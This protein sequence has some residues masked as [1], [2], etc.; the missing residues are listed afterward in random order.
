MYRTGGSR[1]RDHA[2]LRW[3][4]RTSAVLRPLDKA[5]PFFIN[6]A[7]S[8]DETRVAMFV[9]GDIWLY[10]LGTDARIRFTFDP[11]NDFA[12]VWSPDGLQVVFASNRRGPYDLYL[13]NANGT[14]GESPLFQNDARK[15]P[16]DWSRDGRFLLFD[17]WSEKTTFDIGA[18]AMPEGK[19][20]TVL[21]TEFEERSGRSR[22]TGGGSRISPTNPAASRSGSVRSRCPVRR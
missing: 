22:R 5:P 15:L 9:N 20:F 2:F 18:L 1:V 10:D 12:A 7:L 11:G 3:F 17:T 8:P 4:D 19:P 21:A 14:G 13:K 16:S 6:P